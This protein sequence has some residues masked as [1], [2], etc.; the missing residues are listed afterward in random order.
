M[1]EVGAAIAVVEMEGVT[2]DD[3][4]GTALGWNEET[5]NDGVVVEVA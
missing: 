2:A 3:S 1:L 5:E 4:M